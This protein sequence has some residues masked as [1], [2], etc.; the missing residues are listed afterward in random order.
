MKMLDVELSKKVSVI[1]SEAK[2]S[3]DFVLKSWDCFVAIAPRNDNSFL[4]GQPHIF[5][6]DEILQNR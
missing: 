3:H 2:Q 5:F 1:A 6:L 4:F